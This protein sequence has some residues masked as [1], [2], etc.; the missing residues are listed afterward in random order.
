MIL[1]SVTKLPIVL[2]GILTSQDALLAIESGAQAIIVSNHG[3]RQVDGIPASVRRFLWFF[4]I[5]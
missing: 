3:A 1:R 5:R 4:E 2:K